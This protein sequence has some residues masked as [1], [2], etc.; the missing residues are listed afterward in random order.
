MTTTSYTPTWMTHLSDLD[1]LFE[2]KSTEDDKLRV[3]NHLEMDL[4]CMSTE[5][6]LTYVAPLLQALSD[7]TSTVRVAAK[8]LLFVIN[9]E[10][11]DL[12]VDSLLA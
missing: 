3:L 8:A 4:K 1:C 11:D 5:C 6:T 10:V 12:T 2:K 9:S 7:K